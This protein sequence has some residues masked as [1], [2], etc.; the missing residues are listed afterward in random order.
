MF[1]KPFISSLI[2]VSNKVGK[3]MQMFSHGESLGI[4]SSR[5]QQPHINGIL[6]SIFLMMKSSGS[7]IFLSTAAR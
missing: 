7:Y 5:K 3:E 6:C 1:E 4:P 2:I